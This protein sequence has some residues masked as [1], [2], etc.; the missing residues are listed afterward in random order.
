MAKSNLHTIQELKFAMQVKY[1]RR[2]SL[3]QKEVFMAEANKMIKIY[4]LE[5]LVTLGVYKALH[6][7]YRITKND[8][9]ADKEGRFKKHKW[10]E[11]SS[12]IKMLLFVVDLF[13]AAEAVPDEDE[14]LE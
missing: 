4:I 6:P 1:N 5:E 3:T 8:V 10:Y 11:T 12:Q 14:I 13:K 7:K 2:V 9:V